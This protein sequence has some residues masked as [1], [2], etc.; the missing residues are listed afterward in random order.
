MKISWT[1]LEEHRRS[2]QTLDRVRAAFLNQRDPRV[3]PGLKAAM[4]AVAVEG[5]PDQVADLNT[6]IGV[7][8]RRFGTTPEGGAA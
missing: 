1:S 5:H 8:E 2:A 4:D 7:A 6:L 3:N